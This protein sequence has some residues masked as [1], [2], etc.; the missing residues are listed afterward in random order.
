M[1]LCERCKKELK[2]IKRF[3]I[4][5]RKVFAKETGI[6]I[7]AEGR[8]SNTFTVVKEKLYFD[9]NPGFDFSLDNSVKSKLKKLK[10]II[11]LES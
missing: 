6:K 11:E 4:L 7:V 1:L 8:R 2:N 5:D 10:A 3:E 9:S